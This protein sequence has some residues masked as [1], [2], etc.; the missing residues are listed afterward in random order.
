MYKYIVALFLFCFSISA[1]YSQEKTATRKTK[2]LFYT[3]KEILVDSLPVFSPSLKIYTSKKQ[4]VD[5]SYYFFDTAKNTLLFKKPI[6]DTLEITYFNLPDFLT[7]TYTIYDAKKIVPN[8]AGKL[9]TLEEK[10][11]LKATP[12]FNGLQTNGSISRAVTIGNNQNTVLNSNLDLQVSGKLS[13]NVTLRAS[14][15]DSN[16][17]LQEGGYSQ[18]LDEF[19]QIFIE[20]A[21]KDW[22][23]RAGDLFLENRQSSFL[24]FN[25]KVQGLNAK[26]SWGNTQHQTSTNLSAALVRG[27][28]A[29]SN[30]TG[31]EGNQGPYKLRG[32]NGE[33][34]VL[35][36][37]GSERVY[38]NGILLERGENKDY[39]I[40]YNAGEIIFNATK[41]ITSEMRIVVEYQF[42]DRNFTRFLTYG[43]VQH[44][45]NTFKIGSYF[46]SE[47]DVKNQ[48]LQQSLSQEQI[49]VLQNAG[50]DATL[51]NAPS[52]YV[53]SY[54]E[55][56]ILYRK[57]MVGSSEVFQFSTDTSQ[58][59]YNV[60]F[61]FVGANQGNYILISTN[62]IGK[63]YEYIA[64]IA[65]IPQGNYEPIIRLI[66]PTKI[67]IATVT[68]SYNPS[69]KTSV[70]AELAS[71][72]YDKNLYSSINDTDN[73]GVAGKIK[74]KQR[75]FSKNI[76]VDAFS[77]FYYVQ[78]NFKPIERLYN[79]EFTRDW[80]ILNPLGNQLLLNGGLNFSSKTEH[81]W[82]IKGT[83]SFE[84]LMYTETF[85]GNKH[86][87]QSTLKRNGFVFQTNG[88]TMKSSGALNETS[89]V[90]NQTT[91]KYQWHKNYAGASFRYEYNKDYSFNTQ[92][93]TTNSQRFSEF[94]NFIGRGDSTSVFTEIGYLARTNDSLKNN[95]L[96][97]V[98]E[99]FSAYL[100]TQ[101]VKT[102]TRSL[103]LFL[104]YR[105]LKFANG[106]HN[107]PSLNSRI[108]Y[109]D[110]YWNQL[111]QTTT[112]YETASGTIAQQ[113]FT[114]LQVDAG[115]GVYM[116]ND[117]NGN[118]IQ[119]L[120]EFEIATFP[121]L[122]KYVK[123]FLPNQLFI[124]TFQNRL[125]QS[126]TFN[127]AVWQNTTGIKKIA[128]LF[129][130]Q[131][132]YIIDKKIKRSGSNFEWNPFTYNENELIGLNESFRNSLFYNKGKQRHSIT[133][134]Y[135]STAVKNVLNF[136]TQENR[137]RTHQFQYAHL[138]KKFW[139]VQWI[140]T[141]GYSESKS[142]N[143]VSRNF[144][145]Q[146]FDWQPKVSFLFSKNATW[147]LFYKNS[148][149]NNTIGNLE[150][151]K[152]DQ[153]GTHFIWNSTKGL[154]SN[155]SLIY[156]NNNFKG[157]A[158]SPVGFQLLEGLQTGKNITWQFNLQKS[159]TH[160]LDISISYQ[161]R[162]SPTSIA[163]HTGTVQ[164]R[165]F[166]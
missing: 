124:N 69:E 15:Q 36:I 104:N 91:S 150:S 16:I 26:F 162:K 155:G 90:R 137:I 136:G 60:K 49:H 63:I 88:S 156:Y 142:N 149:K 39:S 41:P 72:S 140:T 115:R 159:M 43:G 32:T 76:I 30:F 130:N 44:E 48:P 66:A 18:K 34:Y 85:S 37:S 42:S 141:S 100:K 59:L 31:Q 119:E 83:Y 108:T 166:F 131:T 103:R 164:L 148:S 54:S 21:A 58:T 99:S 128:S 40:D 157:N 86:H 46:Y 161:G 118:G 2:K 81:K 160:Y 55:N 74:A 95:T 80:N 56:K 1:S 14:I 73:K 153:F 65:G 67:Q 127:G 110:N 121:D 144:E 133:Y 132:S 5:S 135:T 165:A 33:L 152:Q 62:A 50:D 134:N 143:Y 22:N 126:L 107:Q 96:Q 8:E 151:L 82:I 61:S 79:I 113:E 53:D 125:S 97:R 20:L 10:K 117:Y 64:P 145:L 27:Q 163:I 75:L 122:A 89:F 147:E 45:R 84:K 98:N 129:Y 146:T 24:N 57:T 116:W 23:I 94:G 13:N 71:S 123:V 25:K 51:M 101:L 4:V 7:K 28:Y 154:T 19:D 70:E 87:F 35:V 105:N 112:F 12:L 11:Q 52:A 102:E 93:L 38:I 77:T 78:E 92:N 3:S 6:Q 109:T 114:Y 47:S 158:L 139:L 120:Q 9:L 106:S 29:K 17:P 138:I 111:I 68:S